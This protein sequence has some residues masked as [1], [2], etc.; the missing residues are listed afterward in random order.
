MNNVRALFY[1]LLTAGIL[2]GE[3][4]AGQEMFVAEGGRL[5]R[6]TTATYYI[7]GRDPIIQDFIDSKTYGSE[8]PRVFPE[9]RGEYGPPFS[10][11]EERQYGIFQTRYWKIVRETEPKTDLVV[12][13][14]M[15][16]V[17]EYHR[18]NI[19]TRLA[20]A[21]AADSRDYLRNLVSRVS[22]CGGVT[23]AA[24]FLLNLAGFSTRVVRISTTPDKVPEGNHISIEY[25]SFE[26]DK[27]VMAEGMDNYFPQKNGLGLSVF[28]VFQG[29]LA[30]KTLSKGGCG[31]ACNP[32][33]VVSLIL[34]DPTFDRAVEIYWAPSGGAVANG[35][36]HHFDR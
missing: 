2:S 21:T 4:V 12:R 11:D 25:F 36:A 26:Q 13:R 32:S 15:A 5:Q 17:H 8:T 18:N 1:G 22:A 20:P 6:T 29:G 31:G 24:S 16:L 9:D 23:K 27:W 7:D 28:E 3:G 19:G 35:K 14:I 30:L 34:P 33:A 10:D